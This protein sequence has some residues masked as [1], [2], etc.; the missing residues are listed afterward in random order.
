MK[1][2]VLGVMVLV[3]FILGAIPFLQFNYAH[4]WKYAADYKTY[5]EQFNTIKDY[6]I[7]QFSYEPDRW[8]SVSVS[9]SKEYR[10]YDPESKSYLDCPDEVDSALELIWKNGF[11]DKEANFDIIRIGENRISFGIE[12]GQ[13]ALVYSPLQRPTYVN[14]PSENKEIFVR[15]IEDGWYHVTI[16][17]Y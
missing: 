12:N 4:T 13:Y 3:P 14:G 11:P 1:K 6:V 8:F 17:S 10:I 5:A 7:E 16:N 2:V 9:E 15:E